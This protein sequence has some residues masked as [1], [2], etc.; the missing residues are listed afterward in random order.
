M[1]SNESTLLNNLQQLSGGLLPFAP[2]LP[3]LGPPGHLQHRQRLRLGRHR[4]GDEGVGLDQLKH[5]WER[6]YIMSENFR[7]DREHMRW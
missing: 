3:P 2:P 5:C 7:S 6:H 4:Q 1:L